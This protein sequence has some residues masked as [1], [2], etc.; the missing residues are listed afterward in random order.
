M[1]I[2]FAIEDPDLPEAKDCINR[3]FDTLAERFD[4]PF[5]R[6]Q[7]NEVDTSIMRLPQGA[8]V[9]ARDSGGVAVGCG[10]LK[11][12]DPDA[13]D[14]K[15]VWI[16]P[17]VRGQ[18]VGHGLMTK[19]ESIALDHGYEYVRLDTNRTL[20]EAIAMYRKRGYIEVPAFNDEFY[21][22]HWFRKK[23]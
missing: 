10:A 2:T 14:I 20:T 21:A 15:H 18:G 16:S 3:Y 1:T 12:V 9:L 11:F 23:L 19:L 13:P 6:E 22:H 17:D 7:T 5:D 4:M 8:L